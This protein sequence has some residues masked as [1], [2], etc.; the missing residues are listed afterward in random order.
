VTTESNRRPF[1]PEISVLY[2]VFSTRPCK[3][4]I[5]KSP[6]REVACGEDLD[7]AYSMDYTIDI[8]VGNGEKNMGCCPTECLVERRK[9]C[10][11][12]HTKSEGRQS[13]AVYTDFQKQG[14][15]ENFRHSPSSKRLRI[16]VQWPFC[17]SLS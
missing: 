5:Y 13:F 17:S 12:G 1:A 14:A 10:L 6:F 9:K 2:K 15:L 11:H 3:P 4:R 16:P 8:Y 7:V